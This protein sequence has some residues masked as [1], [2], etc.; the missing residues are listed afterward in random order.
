[1][2]KVKIFVIIGILLVYSLVFWVLS[3]P[4]GVTA[5]KTKTLCMDNFSEVANKT[6]DG[7]PV[8]ITSNE[9]EERCLQISICSPENSCTIELDV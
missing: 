8:F 4:S 9:N 3:Y 7:K 2:Y 6:L 1:M 5:T